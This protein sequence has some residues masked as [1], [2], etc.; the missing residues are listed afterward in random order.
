VSPRK[1]HGNMQLTPPAR[2]FDNSTVKL[3]ACRSCSALI[4]G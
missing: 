1:H 4:T 3:L 2:A